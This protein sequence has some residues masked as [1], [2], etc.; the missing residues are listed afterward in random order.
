MFLR[1]QIMAITI[2]VMRQQYTEYQI[3]AKVYKLQ[4][5]EFKVG[6]LFFALQ[7]SLSLSFFSAGTVHSHR[8]FFLLKWIYIVYF[9]CRDFFF[10][11]ERVCYFFLF[12]H[13]IRVQERE[14]ERK[15]KSK[16]PKN[17]WATREFVVNKVQWNGCSRKNNENKN[18]RWCYGIRWSNFWQMFPKMNV[19]SI[20]PCILFGVSLSFFGVVVFIEIY[21]QWTLQKRPSS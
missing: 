7:I 1:A 2:A 14:R 15:K 10:E 18:A 5:V 3:Q 20:N 19:L 4:F 6:L 17:G 9:P 12:Q 11:Q 16:R 8:L 13:F 21:R